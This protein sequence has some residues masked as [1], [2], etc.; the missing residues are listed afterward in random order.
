MTD[1]D[2]WE[3]VTTLHRQ[4]LLMEAEAGYR[5]IVQSDPANVAALH[6]LGMILHQQNQSSEALDC[7][8][9]A[10]DLGG[11]QAS[12]LA[13]TAK[14]YLDLDDEPRALELLGRA[15][16]SDPE[17]YGSLYNQA[18]VFSKMKNRKRVWL[19]SIDW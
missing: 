8:G 3:R 18:L 7:L 15:L 13:N 9:R 10:L 14:V 11:E 19:L 4:G 5:K 17:H 16:D 2:Q 12:L 1:K 6:L